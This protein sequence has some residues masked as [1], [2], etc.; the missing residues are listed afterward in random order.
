MYTGRTIA[1]AVRKWQVGLWKKPSSRDTFEFR[2]RNSVGV[3]D[4]IDPS[5]SHSH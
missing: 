3:G 5:K 4:W 2:S 1:E